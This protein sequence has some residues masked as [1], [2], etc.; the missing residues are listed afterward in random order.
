MYPIMLNLNCKPAV[1]IGGGAVAHRKIL[2]LLEAGAAIKVVSPEA[3]PAIQKMQHEHLLKWDKKSVEPSDYKDAFIIFAATDQPEVN[4]R[5]AENAGNHQL[6][7]VVDQPVL[8]N[9]SVPAV[10]RRGKLVMAVS[11][12]GASPILAKRIKKELLA[13][14]SEDYEAYT[15][16]L[17]RCRERIK[18]WEASLDE[19]QSLLHELLEERFIHSRDEQENFIRTLEQKVSF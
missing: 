16:F 4:Q 17:F 12:G 2:G 14:Y 1:V 13:A 8:G 7:N 11:T 15:Q 3:V 5:I 18:E 10:A 6:V 19:K 9:F